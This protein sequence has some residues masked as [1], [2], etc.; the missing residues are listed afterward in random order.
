MHELYRVNRAQWIS[1]I[2]AKC[3]NLDLTEFLRVALDNKN[4]MQ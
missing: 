4:S 2:K 3:Q 1:Y